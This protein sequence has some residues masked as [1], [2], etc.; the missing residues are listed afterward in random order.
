M[1]LRKLISAAAAAALAMSAASFCAFA[2]ENT[3]AGYIYFEADKITIGQGFTVEPVKVPFYEG[4]KGIDVVNRAADV[5]SEDTGYGAYI[6]A[7]ADADI[8]TTVPDAIA[9]V[10]PD[11]TGRNTEGYLSAMDYTTE[12]GWS[13]FV[14][15]EYAQVGIGDYVPADGDVMRFA[16][17]VYGYGADLGVDNSSWGGAAALD[18]AGKRAELIKTCADAADGYTQ[19]YT[20]VGAMEVLAQYEAS[21]DEIDTAAEALRARIDSGDT[22]D[23]F[24][25]IDAEATADENTGDASTAEVGSTAEDSNAANDSAADDTNSADDTKASPDTGVEG[26]AVAFA[27]VLLAG[28]GI[29]MSKKR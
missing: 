15:D 16:F 12:S 28:A 7:F 27:V 4:E 24:A 1:K 3:P 23:E 17:T 25:E 6:T 21:Q 8:E 19:N 5:I 14:N 13:Y 2:E 22:T 29:A 9:A 11:M 20:Y 10:C 18:V 26:A